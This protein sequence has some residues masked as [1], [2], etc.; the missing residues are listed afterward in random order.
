MA[1]VKRTLLSIVL[2]ALLAPPAHAAP[3]DSPPVPLNERFEQIR[4]MARERHVDG[5]T[6]QELYEGAIKGMLEA[7]DPYSAYLDEEDLSR[8]K[9][10]LKGRYSGIGIEIGVRNSRLTVISPIEGGPAE[11]AGLLAGDRI[12]RIEGESTRGWTTRM[13]SEKL[14]GLHSTSPQTWKL[15]PP[16]KA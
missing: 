4:R 3:P 13:A 9:R 8:L 11:A 1:P 15:P 6:D 7:L 16:S 10:R 5:P 12:V 14:L 2:L